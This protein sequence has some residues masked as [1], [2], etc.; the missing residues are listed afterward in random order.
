[1]STDSGT[2][3][4]P[5]GER[6][7]ATDLA[8]LVHYYLTLNPRQLP[9]RYLYD[10]LGST[11]FD[12]ICLLPWYRITRAEA[13][14]LALHGREVFARLGRVSTLV[15]LGSGSGEKLR[16]LV[17]RR[18]PHLGQ[19]EVHLIDVSRAALQ[20]STRA[21]VDIEGVTAVAHEAEY[22][23]GLAAFA[24]VPHSIG[25]TLTLFLGS[26]V[27]NFDRPGAEA[28]LRRIR[29]A[30][31]AGDGLLVGADLLKPEPDLLLAYDDPLGV[32]AAFNRN[33]LVRINR[34]L[35]ADFDI[36]AFR[37]RAL[38]NAAESR[39]EMHLV[40][41]SRQHVRIPGASLEVTF[42][43][44][45]TIWTESSYK[46]EPKGVVRLLERAGFRRLEQWIDRDDGFALTLVEAI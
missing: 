18:S 20:S 33:L 44:D 14:L 25:A 21:L 15:E 10:S 41:G 12:A 13:D 45:E 1:M 34:D 4:H 38:W 11:L 27:G 35:G 6:R 26:N 2:R 30:L 28:M 16:M 40:A 17:Q 5:P 32:T 42:Q 36:A 23:D 43:Q 46:Y 19:L 7:A 39:V 31:A 24:R 8:N 22:E 29:A 3:I 37:H 9:S